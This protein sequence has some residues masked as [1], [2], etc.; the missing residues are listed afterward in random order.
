MTFT[1]EAEKPKSL[2][3]K[4]WF[5][6]GNTELYHVEVLTKRGKHQITFNNI[7]ED[8]LKDINFGG[9]KVFMFCDGFIDTFISFFKTLLCF[10]GGLGTDP[11]KPILGS[12]IPPYMEKANV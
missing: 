8:T 10:L 5:F 4:D 12:H 3:C 11:T 9:F 7:D 6:I 1:I 2:F